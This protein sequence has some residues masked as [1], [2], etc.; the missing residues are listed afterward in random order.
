MFKNVFQCIHILLV[1]S[2]KLLFLPSVTNLFMAITALPKV[3]APAQ[4]VQ[5]HVYYI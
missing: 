5:G 2:W 3:K 4:V 1:M